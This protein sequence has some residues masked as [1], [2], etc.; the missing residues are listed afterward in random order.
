MSRDLSNLYLLLNSD[1][2]FQPKSQ[3]TVFRNDF[4]QGT[5]SYLLLCGSTAFAALLL[6]L[7]SAFDIIVL[8]E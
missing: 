2:V 4:H 3:S 7:L 6:L 5:N 8:G 1:R